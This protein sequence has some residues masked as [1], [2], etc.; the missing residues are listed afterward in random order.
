MITF[1][2]I[3]GNLLGMCTAYLL[4]PYAEKVTGRT[5]IPKLKKLRKE[6]SL[7]FAERKRLAMERLTCILEQAA[8]DVPYY[9]DLFRQHRIDPSKIRKDLKYL[10]DIPYLDKNVLRE[11]G[12]RLIS[13]KHAQA[14]NR[15]QRTG[16]TTG[17]AAIVWY[18]QPGIDW[19]A[20]QN[21]LM[22]EWGGKRRYN[23]EA[24]LSTKFLEPPSLE[25]LRHERKKCF[26]LNR[27]NIY[28]DGF[29]DKSQ[30]QLLTDL[31]KA[32][33]RVVQGHS[34]SMFA[35][36]RFLKK[37][38]AC[39]YGLFDI[40]V[41]TGEMLRDDQRTLL[42]KVFGCQVSNRY[43]AC[44]FGV[45]AQEWCHGPKGELMVSDSLVWPELAPVEGE[46][47]VGE[48]VFTGLRNPAMPLIRYRM[49]DLG[50][51]EERADGWWITKIV[52]RIHDTV[53][54]DGQ[55]YPT[56]Y[57][58]DIFDRCGDITDFQIAT[59]DG[60][61]SE[62]RLVAPAEQWPDIEAAVKRCFPAVPTRRIE[63]QELVFHGVRGK[64]SYIVREDA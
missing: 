51:L 41:S 25:G 64:F 37:H 13:E 49:G 55:S 53:T 31:R 4:Y 6:A 11:Q 15:E 23:R 17:P 20:A 22:L 28:T 29:S 35:L 10:G 63:P 58:Q 62:F 43:G 50:H 5:I 40:F 2:R 26:V 52:G 59:K 19:T 39:G 48:L 7:C 45:M 1:A 34:S 54:I 38:E 32:H 33:A 9:R 14:V 21:I 30:L 8:V 42:E 36:A 60:Q 56:H 12:K 57:I 44:E 46:A 24:H 61:V 47:E 18:D 27:C 16:G 3:A